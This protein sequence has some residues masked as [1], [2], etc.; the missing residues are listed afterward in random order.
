MTTD[1]NRT[2]HNMCKFLVQDTNTQKVTMNVDFN[3]SMQNMCNFYFL[4]V[5]VCVCVCVF[6]CV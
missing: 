3:R 1:F 6:V 5:C 2:M 4:C